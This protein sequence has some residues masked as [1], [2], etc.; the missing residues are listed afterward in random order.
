MSYGIMRK[1]RGLDGR[2]DRVHKVNPKR[3][4]HLSYS[5]LFQLLNT[6]TFPFKALYTIKVIGQP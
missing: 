2:G 3:E 5:L 1:D 6:S 4:Y